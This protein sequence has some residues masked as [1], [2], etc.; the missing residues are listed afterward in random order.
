MYV[1][2]FVWQELASKGLD[3]KGNKSE[4]VDRLSGHEAGLTP[5]NVV[6]ARLGTLVVC[7]M[8]VLSN[9]ETQLAEHVKEGALDVRERSRRTHTE[10][11]RELE[12]DTE[13]ERG[14]GE[15]LICKAS[16]LR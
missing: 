10:R 11:Q 3:T 5:V 15:R 12:R 13:S 8:S 1:C 7:P 9:W 2:M 16:L 6:D 14:E 4:L